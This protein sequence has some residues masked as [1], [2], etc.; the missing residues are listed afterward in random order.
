[1]ERIA[2]NIKDIKVSNT[3]KQISTFLNVTYNNGECEG[4]SFESLCAASN[5]DTYYEYK[6]D[7]DTSKYYALVNDLE[8]Y[9]NNT[10][11]EQYYEWSDRV[12]APYKEDLWNSA[13]GRAANIND[14]KKD[15]ETGEYLL[16]E[17]GN[18]IYENCERCWEGAVNAPGAKYPWMV[19]NYNGEP[20]TVT[21][22]YTYPDG[23]V[24]EVNPWGTKIFGT[25][26]TCGIASLATEFEDNDFLISENRKDGGQSTFDISRFEM[27]LNLVD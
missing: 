26:R 22:K 1:M 10:T 14:A 11:L 20:A 12:N 27:I 6:K 9:N 8:S 24:K 19:V 17:N 16:D 23:T 4:V 3:P 5:I 21:F 2:N 18:Y 13:A 25:E 15:P 7:K